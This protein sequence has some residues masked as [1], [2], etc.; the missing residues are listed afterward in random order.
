MRHA[1]PGRVVP[2]ERSSP[3][4]FRASAAPT[5]IPSERSESRNLI[6]AAP[7]RFLAALGMTGRSC[8]SER[9][10][11]V[12]ESHPLSLYDSVSADERRETAPRMHAEPGENSLSIGSYHSRLDARFKPS[13]Y[14]LLSYVS[15]APPSP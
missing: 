11:R 14:T 3:S 12:E 9:A 2:S 13:N 5:V 6:P 1:L 7:L 4:S 15:I 10:E 8:H